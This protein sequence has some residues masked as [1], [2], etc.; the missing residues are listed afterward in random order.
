MA[1][2]ESRY[3]EDWVARAA[4]DLKRVSPRLQEED[5]EE[6]AVHLQQAIEKYLKGYLISKGWRLKPTHD[7][8]LLLDEAVKFNSNL[9]RFRDLCLEVT[10]YYIQERYPF[11]ITEPSSEEI[12]QLLDLTKE[13]VATIQEDL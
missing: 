1:E 9:E 6:A 4:K 3:P 11:F 5:I 13:L 7:L 2:K 12:R 10:P 8:E